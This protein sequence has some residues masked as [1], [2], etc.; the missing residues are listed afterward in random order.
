MF[1]E[2]P[3]SD[4]PTV[5]TQQMIEVDRAMMEDFRIELMQMMENAGRNLAHL[6]RMRYLNGNPCGKKVLVLAGSGGNGGGSL[7]AARRLSAW[8]AD[9]HLALGQAPDKMTPLPAHQLDILQRMGIEGSEQVA[10]PCD[11]NMES[12]DLILDGLI[13]YSLKDNPY[14]VI[15]DLITAT[16]QSDTPVVSL[17]TPSGVDTSDGTIYNPA[18]KADATLTLALPKVGLFMQR[19]S[20]Q[21]GELYLGD[22]SVP[23]ELYESEVLNLDVGPLFA[24]SEI[25]KIVTP[26]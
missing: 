18:I 12:F 20:D 21:T 7:V 14:G 4:V 2:V 24:E 23:P 19:V 26:A 11:L 9:I 17:D 10:V 15:G 16:N 25:L 3:V 13:G 5:D 22:I 8:G 1:P 6:S